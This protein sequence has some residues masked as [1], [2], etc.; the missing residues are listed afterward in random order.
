[1]TNKD[2]I[3][4][5]ETWQEAAGIGLGVAA[6]LSPWLTGQLDNQS[7]VVASSAAGVVVLILSCVKLMI[8][9]RTL[10][11]VTLLSGLWLLVGPL[12]LGYL[13]TPLS[14]LHIVL[15]A[16]ITVLSALE[17]WQDW[18]LSEAELAQYGTVG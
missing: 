18:N 2:K 8:L 1:M 11:I 14:F 15:G 9:N 4:I 12:L 16:A 3:E 7:I 6:A 10:E 17:L 5:H 13:G